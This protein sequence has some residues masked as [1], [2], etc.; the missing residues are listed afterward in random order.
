MRSF[1][2]QQIARLDNLATNI[3]R[4]GIVIVFIWIGA[5]KFFTYEADGIVPFVANSPFM[6]F[7]YNH[8]DEYAAHLNKE[9]AF[10]VENH[11]WHIQNNTYGFSKGLGIFLM[12][13]GLLVA[14][15][16]VAPLWSMWGSILIFLMTLGTLS[17]LVTTPEAWVGNLG[18]TDYGF[19]FLSGRG[20]LVIKD[21]VILGGAL[22]T[23][24]QSARL[25]LQHKGK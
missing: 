5:L 10:I 15:H 12:S 20:R 16:R 22:V 2:I 7:F 18:D 13:L 17:F 24:S 23:M 1:F 25:Y 8:P 19:P 3:L 14:L 11:Q 21:V 4:A 9:G 6:R